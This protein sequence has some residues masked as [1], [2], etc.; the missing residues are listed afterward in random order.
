MT[1]RSAPLFSLRA[2]PRASTRAR[3]LA[4]VLLL[5]AA[6][7]GAPTAVLR[8]FT[9]GAPFWLPLGQAAT[10][11]DGETVVRFA[12]VVGDSRCPP[13]AVCVWQGEVNVEIGVRIGGDEELLVRINTETPPKGVTERGRLIELL[14]VEG[15]NGAGIGPTDSYRAQ[16]R[17]TF[18]R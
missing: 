1:G 15:G 3:A 14:A 17:V 16:L 12:K 13:G 8:S 18:V 7:C 6:A 5:A 11:D 9:P 2:S 10:G 4:V